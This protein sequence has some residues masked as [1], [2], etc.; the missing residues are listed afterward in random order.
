[1]KTT[2]NWLGQIEYHFENGILVTFHNQNWIAI[3]HGGTVMLTPHFADAKEAITY[4][5]NRFNLI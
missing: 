3:N 2:V 4:I 5:N 1:M